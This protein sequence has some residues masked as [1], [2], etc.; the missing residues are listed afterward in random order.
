MYH[1]GKCFYLLLVSYHKLVACGGIRV[2]VRVMQLGMVYCG[3]Q[4]SWAAYC[5][6]MAAIGSSKVIKEVMQI[7]YVN[8]ASFF[9]YRS[10][11]YRSRV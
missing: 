4:A 2:L 5:V 11:V 1:I 6:T 9:V 3:L 10:L 7:N 8:H